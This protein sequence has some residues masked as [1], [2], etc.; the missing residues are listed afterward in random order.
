MA[1]NDK[2]KYYYNGR[3][4]EGILKELTEDSAIFD[5]L[6]LLDRDVFDQ[7]AI[8]LSQ[9][10]D[11]SDEIDN[12]ELENELKNYENQFK[13]ND[14]PINKDVFPTI[15]LEGGIP[16]LQIETNENSEQ[17]SEQNNN[18]NTKQPILHSNKQ[19]P[20]RNIV[21]PTS[22]LLDKTKKEPENVDIK[23]EIALPSKELF[24]VLNGSLENFET[25]FLDYIINNL[26]NNFIKE[27]IRNSIKKHYNLEV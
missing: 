2:Y 1:V 8:N 11:L 22:A 5:N 13:G 10:T 23:L 24:T 21:N 6:D 25:D 3:E 20:I 26:D 27:Q 9:N 12:D 4:K 16:I 19:Q 15:D 7:Q 18:Q 17:N 14:E